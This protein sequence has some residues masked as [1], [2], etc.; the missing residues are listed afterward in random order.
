MNGD[1]VVCGKGS[2]G[3]AT[4]MKGRSIKNGDSPLIRRFGRLDYDLNERPLN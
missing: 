4:S 2:H 3:D 1:I